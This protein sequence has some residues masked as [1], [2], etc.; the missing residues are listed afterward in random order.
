[1]SPET[2]DPRPEGFTPISD[3]QEKCSVCGSILPRDMMMQ[4][5][6]KWVCAAC[7][8]S[9]LQ[10]VQQGLSTSGQMRYGGFWIRVGARIID[11]IILQVANYFII[12]AISL[13]VVLETAGKN[14]GR[15]LATS[16]LQVC[17]GLLVAISY[18]VW[19]LGK[20]RATP[21]KMICGLSVV[22]PD[23]EKISYMRAFGRYL[24]NILSALILGIGY[25][26]AGFDQEKRALHD[27]ICDTRVI[28]K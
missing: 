27:R 28:R 10:M 17:V 11:T 6:E 4:F 7:K 1:M 9:Y 16:V 15:L 25:I 26:M 14:P 3:S 13:F 8:P 18:E 23:G 22:R 12:F 5:G 19:F 24:A 21:G 20:F 2:N